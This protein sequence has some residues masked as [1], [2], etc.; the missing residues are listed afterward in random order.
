MK[1]IVFLYNFDVIIKLFSPN[2][3]LLGMILLLPNHFFLIP[4]FLGVAISRGHYC[5]WEA[6]APPSP[7]RPEYRQISSSHIG[8]EYWY[9]LALNIGTFQVHTLPLNIGISQLNI[10][11]L[12]IG[13]LKVHILALTIGIFKVHI[14]A[15][16]IGLYWP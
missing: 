10:L 14:L 8:P 1:N 15:L 11:T 4:T 5:R 13:I 6:Q 16:N 12:N 3:H 9:M 7:F 2:T